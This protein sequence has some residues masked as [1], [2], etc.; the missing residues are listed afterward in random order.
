LAARPDGGVLAREMKGTLRVARHEM[1]RG[2]LSL[3]S[4]A[5]FAMLMLLTV[6]GA[7]GVSE[8]YKGDLLKTIDTRVYATPDTVLFLI[9]AYTAL[10]VPIGAV[11]LS[12]DALAYE[13]SKGTMA[14]L[15]VKPFSRESLALG[16]FLGA[17]ATMSV[18]ITVCSVVAIGMIAYIAGS[19]PSLLNSV[20]F[21]VMSIMLA[22][23]YIGITMAASVMA[24]Q[25]ADAVMAGVAV[26]L[27]FTVFWLLLPMGVAFAMHWKYDVNDPR[28]LAF[29]NRAD[30]FNPNGVYNL[31]LAS[32]SGN[33]FITTGVPPVLQA[34]SV[35]LWFFIPLI[36]FIVAF[37]RSEG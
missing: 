27:V 11:V 31:C 22:G 36:V 34:L 33:G 21:I 1:L 35:M 13:R 25:Q 12:F 6:G 37:G 30:A 14:L 10:I 7:Y 3:R 29:S 15:L 2:L 18:H 17:L 28:Y 8:L 32:S 4:G 20:L 16:K 9:S 19:S 5:I 24:R 26:W 23:T